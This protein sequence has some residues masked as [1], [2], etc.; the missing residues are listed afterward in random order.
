MIDKSPAAIRRMFAQVAPRYDV[1]NRVMSMHIDTRWRRIVA[2]SVV[3][4]PGL[5]LDLAAGTGD[6]TVDL[7]RYGHHRVISADFTF[8]MLERG[9]A[10][11]ASLPVTQVGADAL[12]LPFRSSR[13]DAVTIAFGIRNFADPAAG[14]REVRRVL[15]PGGVCAVLE[16]SRPAPI[17]NGFYQLYSRHLLPRL[18]GFIT[19]AR[20][21]YEYLPESVRDF[22]HGNAFLDLMSASGYQQVSARRL[23]GGIVTYYRGV[24]P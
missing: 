4:C 7:V 17:I 15:K 9:R 21:P 13:F 22:P 16:F 20:A 23:S 5:V 1:A 6:L 10:K 18:G 14:L 11:L 8:E 24:A 12:Q 3:S 19:G 2:S